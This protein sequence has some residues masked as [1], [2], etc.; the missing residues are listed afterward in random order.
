[1]GLRPKNWKAFQHYKDRRP[2]WIRLYH[3]LLDSADWWKL[4]GEDAKFLVCIWLMASEHEDGQLPALADLA[5]RLRI[6]DAKCKQLMTRLQA[7]LEEE[8]SSL[9]AQRKQLATPE[10]EERRG[11]AEAEA[12]ARAARG[13]HAAIQPNSPAPSAPTGDPAEDIP[14]GLEPAQYAT[15]L[16]EFMRIPKPSSVPVFAS[17]TAILPGIAADEGCTLA[18]ATR[19]ILDRMREAQ[20]TGPVKWRFWLEDGG[21]KL[22]EEQVLSVE[23]LE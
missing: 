4:R 11:E 9:L 5:F 15:G 22:R 8:G 17:L 3:H 19:R 2:P 23:G 1:M 21:W 14:E 13:P 12:E 10:A 16:M 6:S 18:E 7:W 20:R